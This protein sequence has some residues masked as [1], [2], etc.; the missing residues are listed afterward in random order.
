M[1]VRAYPGGAA[2]GVVTKNAGVST[3][4][5]GNKVQYTCPAGFGATVKGVTIVPT[6]GAATVQVQLILSG[7][8]VIVAQSTTGIAFSVPHNLV[9][10]DTCRVNVSVAD[11]VGVIDC[12]ISVDEYP[13]V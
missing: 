1:A 7:S 11:A 2:N 9:A 4:T 6:A 3:A 13:V 10:G 8:T 12:V 5:T